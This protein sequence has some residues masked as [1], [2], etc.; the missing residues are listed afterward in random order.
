MQISGPHWAQGY[1]L[2]WHTESSV[3]A[4]QNQQGHPKFDTI[5]TD[6]GEALYKLKYQSDFTQIAPLAHAISTQICPRL[7]KISFV[8]PVPPSKPRQRQPVIELAQGVAKNLNKKFTEQLLLKA[9]AVGQ[10]K[11]MASKQEK[12]GH[13][14]GKLLL[15]DFLNQGRWNVLLVDDIYASG[16][17]LE[18]ACAMLRS[19]PKINDIFVAVASRTRGRTL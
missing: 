5:R 8:I 17:S 18:A 7:G 9:D 11:N 1:V 10:I 2:D 3:I 14:A 6:V 19:S 16:A 12:V 4:G 13:L 15:N